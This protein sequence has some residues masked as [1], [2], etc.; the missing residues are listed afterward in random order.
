MICRLQLKAL[1]RGIEGAGNVALACCARS[2]GFHLHAL[3][4]Y[5]ARRQTFDVGHEAAKYY[6]GCPI[7]WT[8]LLDFHRSQLYGCRNRQKERRRRLQSVAKQMVVGAP[9]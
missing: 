5:G 4:F 1:G 9:R 8:L 2:R 3:R 6:A 7:L